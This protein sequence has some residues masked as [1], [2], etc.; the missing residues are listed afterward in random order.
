[1]HEYNCIYVLFNKFLQNVVALISQ[2]YAYCK[3][4]TTNELQSSAITTKQY[5]FSNC[6]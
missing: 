2:P 3:V 1:M 4:V 5:C 6:K